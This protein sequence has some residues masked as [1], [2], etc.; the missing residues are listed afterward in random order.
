MFIPVDE[1]R[2]V[3]ARCNLLI[4]ANED[5]HHAL[6]RL[7]TKYGA[8]VGERRLRR[9]VHGGVGPIEVRLEEI[10]QQDFNT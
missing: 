1:L 4:A 9:I 7:E 8:K 10:P 2:E 5:Y 6:G 3:E